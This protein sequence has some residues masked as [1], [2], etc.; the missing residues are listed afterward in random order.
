MMTRNEG[1]AAFADWYD[2]G[3]VGSITFFR[4]PDA[5]RID[6]IVEETIKLRE[7]TPRVLE[8]ASALFDMLDS[9]KATLYKD[10][11]GL[12]DRVK[13]VRRP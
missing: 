11:M 13:V 2:S 1:L 6:A 12:P 9:E 4:S 8:T 10:K 3:C 7:M 5:S